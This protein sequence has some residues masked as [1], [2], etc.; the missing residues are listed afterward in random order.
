MGP[1][2]FGGALALVAGGWATLVRSAGTWAG[3]TNLQETDPL[4]WA[5]VL[6]SFAGAILVFAIMIYALLRFRD[7]ATRRRRYG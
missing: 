7:P 2:S 1:R 3:Q 5:L 6:I 4:F